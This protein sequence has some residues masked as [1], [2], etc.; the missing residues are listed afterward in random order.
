MWINQSAKCAVHIS[1]SLLQAT[2]SRTCNTLHVFLISFP[3]KS[4]TQLRI[5]DRKRQVSS[6]GY[7]LSI[8]I[9]TPG[10]KLC[11][12]V[13][14]CTRLFGLF[15]VF[16]KREKLGQPAC[17]VL[18][19]NTRKQISGSPAQVSW[20]LLNTELPGLSVLTCLQN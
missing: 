15:K 18:D 7:V 3:F 1:R 2:P 10:R 5:A 9:S 17:T 16:K 13:A 12:S 8:Y 19:Y 4:L 20:D 6:R 14:T 11:S